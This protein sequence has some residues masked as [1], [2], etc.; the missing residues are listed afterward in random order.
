MYG[1]D[2]HDLVVRTP[3]GWRFAEKVC[4]ARWQLTVVVDHDV[5]EHR[6]TY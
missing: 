2:Y 4:I 3:D 6:A 1:G 5:P